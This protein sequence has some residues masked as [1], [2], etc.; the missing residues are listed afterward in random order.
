M[1]LTYRMNCVELKSLPLTSERENGRSVEAHGFDRKEKRIRSALDHLAHSGI[2]QTS[3]IFRM[4]HE[5]QQKQ[6]T[7]N[8]QSFHISPL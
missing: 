7:L 4:A 8:K 5:L 6:A 2:E 3:T 1:P